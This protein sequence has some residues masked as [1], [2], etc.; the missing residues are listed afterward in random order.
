MDG[1]EEV[2]LSS[3]GINVVGTLV[4]DAKITVFENVTENSIINDKNICNHYIWF[5]GLTNPINT[6]CLYD[7]YET[8]EGE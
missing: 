1:K 6:K 5:T 2:D 3:L 7:L 4:A 8:V